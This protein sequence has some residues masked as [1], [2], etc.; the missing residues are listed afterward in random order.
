[1][2]MTFLSLIYPPSLYIQIHTLLLLN[3]LNKYFYFVTRDPFLCVGEVAEQRNQLSLS[4]L[5]DPISKE[6]KWI[7]LRTK[8]NIRNFDLS[9][10]HFLRRC[11]NTSGTETEV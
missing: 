6:I 7:H 11:E 1:M 3:M 5:R 9:F 10:L 2:G 8:K 4:N